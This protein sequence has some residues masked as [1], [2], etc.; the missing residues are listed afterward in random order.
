VDAPS[1]RTPAAQPPAPQ[2]QTP[3]PSS[4]R[5]TTV[6]DL[7]SGLRA[8]AKTLEPTAGMRLA[9][10]SFLQRR[11]LIPSDLPYSDFVAVRLL[12]ESTRD[13]GL[14][15]LQWRITDRE[16]RSDA[17]WRQWQAAAAPSPLR[18]TATAECDELSALF[19][20]LVRSLGVH[21]VGL[22]WP[23]PN[24]T[25]AVW[26]IRPRVRPPI[27][28]VVPTTQIFLAESDLF[29]T[30]RFEP[31]RQRQIYEYTRS[32]A[33]T[34]LRLPPPLLAFFLAQ[35]RRYGGA[36][37]LS[38]QRL[39]YLREAVFQGRL[40]ASQAAVLARRAPEN[41]ARDGVAREDAAAFAAFAEAMGAR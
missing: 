28:V 13:A 17:I 14:W 30:D 25:V 32:D 5:P 22:F 29:D 31:W 36:G 38:L 24:H 37:D 23:Y 34:S 11:G 19:A 40:S 1:A 16:P 39:R 4:A 8:T 18:P 21:G 27:R 33:A 12:F 3:R 35:T 7:L 2:A 20:F 26:Q 41:G 6:A 9:Y 10:A 15:N